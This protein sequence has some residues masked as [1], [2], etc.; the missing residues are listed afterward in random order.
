MKRIILIIIV[1]IFSV[2]SFSQNLVKNPGFEELKAPYTHPW[3]CSE[4]FNK[5]VSN[6]L[7]ISLISAEIYKYDSS[8][9]KIASDSSYFNMLPPQHSGNYLVAIKTYGTNNIGE[10]Y[11]SYIQGELI[12]PMIKGKKYIIEFSIALSGIM[13]Q[14]VLSNN[15]GV[16]FC[17]NKLLVRKSSNYLYKP[18]INYNQIPPI[19]GRDQWLKLSWEYMAQDN[20][21]YF[22]IGNFFSNADTKIKY[23]DKGGYASSYF[24]DDVR[25]EEVKE[26][27]SIEEI[28]LLEKMELNKPLTLNNIYFETGKSN[29]LDSSYKELNTLATIL[30]NN[31][32]MIIQ[33]SGY[34]DNVGK[35]EVNLILSEARANAVKQYLFENGVNKN[36]LIAKG[37][38]SS[39][40]KTSNETE[41]GRAQNRRVEIIV[42][43]NE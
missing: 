26:N 9:L 24:I 4:S 2:T 39:N 21:R 3:M 41:E 33:I 35:A 1:S 37:Y 19:T 43:K 17:I 38:G 13:G 42:L 22:T 16:Y 18:Q 29:L 8:Y 30:K 36:S 31:P 23:I 14:G 28:K 25:I 34:T 15:I 20:Y 27:D 12:K 7:S 5:F 32:K 11:R 10:P 40:P 6:W